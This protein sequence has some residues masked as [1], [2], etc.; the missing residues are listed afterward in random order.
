[1]KRGYMGQGLFPY[2]DGGRRCLQGRRIKAH[3][4]NHKKQDCGEFV[5]ISPFRP[6][7]MGSK[8]L[9]R[10]GTK[11]TK[12]NKTMRPQSHFD[13]DCERM[14]IKAREKFAVCVR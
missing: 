3:S 13:R 5:T 10:C 2:Q 7:K 6:G 4:L 9:F 14:A 1:M 12:A 8:T 11:E